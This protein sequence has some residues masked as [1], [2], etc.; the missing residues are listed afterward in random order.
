MPK[1]EAD[2]SDPMELV[3]EV[4]QLESEGPKLLARCLAEEFLALGRDQEQVMELFRS[5]EYALAH[6][7]WNELGDVRVFLIVSELARARERSRTIRGG[8]HA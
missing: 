3:G 6:R 2:P 1:H 8:I 4:C 7:A 5:P